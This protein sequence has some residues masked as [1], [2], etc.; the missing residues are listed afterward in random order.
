LVRIPYRAL[1][2]R[3]Y[4]SSISMFVRILFIHQ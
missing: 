4:V 3:T 1:I 2:S